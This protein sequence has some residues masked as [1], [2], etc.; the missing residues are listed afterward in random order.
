LAGIEERLQRLRNPFRTAEAFWV[1]EIINP[2]RTRR[3]LCEFADMVEK[4]LEPGMARFPP[5]P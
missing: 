2:R 4:L 1:E 3:L 5:R